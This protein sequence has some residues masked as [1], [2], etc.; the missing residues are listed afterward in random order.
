[1]SNISVEEQISN[2]KN[3]GV[4]GDDTLDMDGLYE[5]W[6]KEELEETPYEYLLSSFA[7]LGC[8]QK[9]RTFQM[10]AIEPQPGYADVLNELEIMTG[11]VL[12]LTDINDNFK[13]IFAGSSEKVQ[14]YT[15]MHRA[16]VNFNC[17]G[18]A[19]CW[20]LLY[21]MEYLDHNLFYKFN[22]LLKSHGSDLQIYHMADFC[23]FALTE[24]QLKQLN[25]QIGDQIGAID[26]CAEEDL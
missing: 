8:C 5:D 12:G 4:V 22:E 20:N 23:Y 24:A 25:E 13:D 2:L 9:M 21:E 11:G 10:G 1:M 14:T 16:I 3:W 7:S 18:E 26:Y 15:E 17:K 19:V 6:E